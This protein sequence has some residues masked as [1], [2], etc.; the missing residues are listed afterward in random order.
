[1]IETPLAPVIIWCNT[2]EDLEECERHTDIYFTEEEY[3]D[4]NQEL[5]FPL[6][7]FRDISYY[8][9]KGIRT[10]SEEEID[11]TYYDYDLYESTIS[12]TIEEFKAE[13]YDKVSKDLNLVKI[14][15]SEIPIKY[16]EYCI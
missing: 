8:D 14:K 1:M 4:E 2:F 5:K 9:D 12:N 7:Y 3:S 10:S 15:P 16:P 11:K 6:V 13:F